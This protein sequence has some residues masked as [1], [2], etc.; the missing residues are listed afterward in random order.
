[1]GVGAVAH[2]LEDVL[3]SVKGAMPIHCV[4]SAP[5][6]VPMT[7]LR[8]IHIAMVAADAGRH[9]AAVGAWVE[10]VRTARAEPGGGAPRSAACCASGSRPGA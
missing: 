3:P 10:V 2:V 6:W 1:M 9:D 4:P 7:T 5:M 8:P